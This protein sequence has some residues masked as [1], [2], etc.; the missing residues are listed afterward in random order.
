ML[1]TLNALN[2][3]KSLPK[4]ILLK[5]APDL[6]NDQLDDI[7][8]IVICTKIDGVIATNT[9]LNR[10]GLQSNRKFEMGGLSG[11]PL[12][13]SSTEVIRYLVK[14]SKNAF[15]II[16]VEESI[17]LRMHLKNSMQEPL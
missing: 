7:I 14:K 5:I 11:K 8:D 16:G 10:E 2:K 9:T 13:Q 3:E 17:L 12:S 15:P 4:P 1:S 6:T